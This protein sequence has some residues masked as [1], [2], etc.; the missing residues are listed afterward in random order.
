MSLLLKDMDMIENEKNDCKN[1]SE[2]MR[3]EIVTCINDI[4][5]GI[6]IEIIHDY[7]LKVSKKI[8]Q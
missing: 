4:E 3:D 7:I 6:I 2:A 1:S 8:V 5:S